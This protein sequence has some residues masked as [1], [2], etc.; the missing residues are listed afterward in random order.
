MLNVILFVN[1]LFFLTNYCRNSGLT[2]IREKVLFDSWISPI[3]FYGN[4]LMKHNSIVKRLISLQM[5]FYG[6]GKCVKSSKDK[7]NLSRTLIKCILD[8]H[9]NSKCNIRYIY[10]P[11]FCIF[12]RLIYFLNH[13]MLIAI[14]TVLN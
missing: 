2:L 11:Y 6:I 1:I 8:R 4:Q 7:R 14:T 12:C 3:Q 13:I 9:L 5:N 10:N